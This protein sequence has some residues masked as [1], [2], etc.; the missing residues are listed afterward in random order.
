ME[1]VNT[2]GLKKFLWKKDDLK[3]ESE[4]EEA[5]EEGYRKYEIRKRKEKRN[6][7]ILIA[8]IILVI[9]GVLGYFLL[10]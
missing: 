3:L 7:I 2:G 5:I 6:L 1:E 4:R 10:R 9:L 8:V